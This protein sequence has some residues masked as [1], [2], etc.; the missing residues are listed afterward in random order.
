MALYGVALL[1][2]AIAYYLLELAIIRQQ[3]ADGALAKALGSDVKGKVPSSLSRRGGP[4]F[5]API[6]GARD[7]CVRRTHV[8]RTRPPYRAGP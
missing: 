2:P 4:R 6:L 3:G 8:A 7:L 1:M 5:R